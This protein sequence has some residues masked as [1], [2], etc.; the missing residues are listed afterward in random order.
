MSVWTPLR[1]VVGFLLGT[2]AKCRFFV[3]QWESQQSPGT[4]SGKIIEVIYWSC[5]LCCID[6]HSL[7]DTD[8]DIFYLLGL[9]ATGVNKK[10]W[11]RRRRQYRTPG[12]LPDLM[13]QSRQPPL[14]LWNLKLLRIMQCSHLVP[15]FV[16]EAT[17]N[18]RYCLW[19]DQTL[20]TDWP[21]H[22]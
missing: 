7:V 4:I 5:N 16:W 14:R 19:I 2:K 15:S 20:G 9:P 11:H 8:S 17:F 18:A 13:P 21:S 1:C 10:R 6:A 22:T 3:W 12:Q